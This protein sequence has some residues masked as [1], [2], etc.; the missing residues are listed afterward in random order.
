MDSMPQTDSTLQ[1]GSTCFASSSNL[2]PSPEMDSTRVF[3]TNRN[4]VTQPTVGLLFRRAFTSILR[5]FTSLH[6]EGVSLPLLLKQAQHIAVNYYPC[7]SGAAEY[8]ANAEI[9][10][11]AVYRAV[12][13]HLL[14]I[15]GN[16]A[17]I[18]ALYVVTACNGEQIEEAMDEFEDT[19]GKLWTMVILGPKEE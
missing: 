13:S 10:A 12:L 8:Y 11:K 5:E 14:R 19:F 18:Q 16:Q 6:N 1:T 9:V 2:D 4:L 17:Q 7:T 3:N 15:Y